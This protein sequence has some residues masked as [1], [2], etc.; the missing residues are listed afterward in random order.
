[1]LVISAGCGTTPAPPAHTGGE[2]EPA[3]ADERQILDRLNS[4][5]SD[6]TVG[7]IAVHAEPPYFA[8]SGSTCRWLVL[9]RPTGG[10]SRRLACQKGSRWFYAPEVLVAPISAP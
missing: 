8:A 6:Q 4:W 1:M 5:T 3:S 10:S 9:T 7:S 2:V